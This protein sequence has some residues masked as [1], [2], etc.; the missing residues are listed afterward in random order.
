M[1]SPGKRLYTVLPL[2]WIQKRG[3]LGGGFPRFD[4]LKIDPHEM[5]HTCPAFSMLLTTSLSSCFDPA[6]PAT[7]W[8]VYMT[9]TDVILQHRKYQ[10][11]LQNVKLFDRGMN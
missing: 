10:C 1:F 8:L 3:T 4:E 2:M 5:K 7:S 11:L 9:F 6:I